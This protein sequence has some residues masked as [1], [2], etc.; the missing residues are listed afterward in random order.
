M[1]NKK[2]FEMVY[3]VVDKAFFPLWI[4]SVVVFVYTLVGYYV[5]KN[6]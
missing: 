5:G 3:K 6:G 4:V 1:N 2:V